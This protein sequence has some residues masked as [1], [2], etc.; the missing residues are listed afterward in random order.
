V[1]GA[2]ARHATAGRG[3]GGQGGVGPG[4]APTGM[5]EGGQHPRQGEGV[6]GQGV[7]ARL[8][9][10]GISSAAPIPQSGG[11]H[12]STVVDAKRKARKRPRASGV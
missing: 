9:V 2:W 1:R 10:I 8:H 7:P 4:G 6:G 5:C 11:M 12:V 3:Q